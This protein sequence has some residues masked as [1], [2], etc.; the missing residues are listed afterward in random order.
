VCH[1][2]RLGCH[3]Q[4]KVA[5]TPTVPLTVAATATSMEKSA[6]LLLVEILQNRNQE[7]PKLLYRVD[8]DLLIR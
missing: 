8:V 7:F 5:I 3:S 6:R 2:N 4:K 1:D